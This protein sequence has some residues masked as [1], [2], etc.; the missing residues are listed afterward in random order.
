[1]RKTKKTIK[2]ILEELEKTGLVSSACA[3]AK[4]PRSTYYR[5]LNTDIEFRF[6]AEEAIEI[7]RSNMVDFAESTII[8]NI[9]SGSQ[10]AA[11]FYLRNNDDRYRNSYAR[12]YWKQV[13]MIKDKYSKDYNTLTTIRNALF[14][15]LPIKVLK[16]FALGSSFIKQESNNIDN[17]KLNQ[18]EIEKEAQKVIGSDMYKNIT[19]KLMELE[20]ISIKDV[21]RPPMPD[22]KDEIT[23][24]D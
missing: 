16:D 13:D 12:D 2:I 23:Y 8:K 20:G 21:D 5:W 1:M 24:S 15:A 11:E 17:R 14:N 4:I 7:G 9:Q 10:R 6:Q 3:K 19:K 22:E 18:Q